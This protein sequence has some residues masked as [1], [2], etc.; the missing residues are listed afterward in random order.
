M[1]VSHS[2]VQPQ[3]PIL[4]SYHRVLGS[5]SQPRVVVPLLRYASDV[6]S[7]SKHDNKF[8][9]E[10]VSFYIASSKVSFTET[11]TGSVL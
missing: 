8:L 10:N 5:A 9:C 7:G 6:C 11:A 4:R 2:R 1:W 3:R